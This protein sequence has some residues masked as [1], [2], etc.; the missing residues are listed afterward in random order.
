VFAVPQGT[1][2]P[3]L[4]IT[5][6]E[7]HARIKFVKLVHL[8]GFIIKK[9]LITISPHDRSGFQNLIWTNLFTEAL[10]QNSLPHM[11]FPDMQFQN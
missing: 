1:A 7:F 8:V 11:R 4:G 10:R 3:R 6:V 2:E 9:S 5:D